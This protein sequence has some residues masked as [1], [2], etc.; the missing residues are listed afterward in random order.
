MAE[1]RVLGG[2]EFARRL[3]I[4]LG[5]RDKR[6]AFF[7]GAGCSVSSGIPAAHALVCDNWLPRLKEIAAPDA[8]G[9]DWVIKKIPGWDPKRP[10]ASYGA[11][12]ESLFLQPEERQREIERLCDG[13]FPGF[14][15]AVVAAL[16]AHDGGCFSVALTTNFDDLLADALY[17]FTSARPLVIQHESLAS[18]I[19][20]TR[21]RPLIVKL[22]GDNRLS[23]LNTGPETES[24]KHQLQ[25][26]VPSLLHDGGL[27]IVGYGGNDEG[28]ASLFKS[29]P[30]EALPLGIYWISDSEP[31]DPIRGWLQKRDAMWVQEADFDET[32]LLLQDAVGLSHPTEDRIQSVFLRY[33]ETY[34]RL[35]ASIVDRPADGD[36]TEELKA[37]VRRTDKAA[38][39]SWWTVVLEAER[40]RRT[41]PE[42]TQAI[43]KAGL[44]QYPTSPDLLGAYA[45]FLVN[46]RQDL[47]GAEEMYEH[48]I[49]A[50]PQHVRSLGNYAVFLATKRKDFDRAETMYERTIAAD[51]QYAPGLS[52]Y[53]IFL[54]DNRKEQD[55]AETMYERAI[56]A[57]P[58][59]APGLSNYAIFLATQRKDFDRAER[60]HERAIAADPQHAPSL[61]NYG[62]FL[63][64]NRKEQD[65][66]ETMYERAIAADPQHAPSLGNYAVVL[67]S[68]RKDFDRAETMYER[69]IA[70][71]P[72]YAPGLS[73]YAIFLAT[74]R[75]DLDRAERMHERAIAADPQHAPSLSS[76]GNLL[77]A[78]RGDIERA[79]TMYERAIAA[80]PEDADILGS[81]AVAIALSRGDYGR[82]RKM[83]ERAVKADPQ[84]VSNLANYGAL[85]LGTGD[86]AGG[87]ALVKQSLAFPGIAPPVE[88]GI[89]FNRLANGAP[90]VR[91]EALGKIWELL[92][93]GVRCEGWDFTLNL[94]QAR[95]AG[96]ENIEMLTVLSEVITERK[97][98]DALDAFPELTRV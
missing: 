28:I 23:P 32:M 77:A 30:P 84:H 62:H 55:R 17:L 76:Y 69:T 73:N 5:D 9:D 49:A 98:M 54:A 12:M 50:D 19:R 58:Q 4:S 46:D 1:M 74:Q 72:L 35:S 51:P 40:T 66:A 22:H 25:Q 27:I 38:R 13:K 97:D 26:H 83:F 48:A 61:S 34:E 63:A 79:E 14:G 81:Y 70:A 41:D 89:S 36:E 92:S 29:L 67:A 59:H 75:K 64:D 7:L 90:G 95:K 52:N 21:S 65:R 2:S 78:G 24:L 87:E 60:M 6:Y 15:Y 42:M 47:D 93:E 18:F 10:A 45:L 53:A 44:E 39:G 88:L 37:A 94:A 86:V 33:R 82:A 43:Y 96:H 71:D 57:D 20:P 68:E 3:K 8:I 80:D 31:G 56:A 85:L 11:V 16:M 91:S